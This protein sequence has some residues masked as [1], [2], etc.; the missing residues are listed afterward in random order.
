MYNK[1]V[2]YFPEITSGAAKCIIKKRLTFQTLLQGQHNVYN[3]KVTYFPEITSVA[4]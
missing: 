3:N 2:I 1:K 4:A